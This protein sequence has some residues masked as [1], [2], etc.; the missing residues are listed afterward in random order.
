MILTL[1]GLVAVFYFTYRLF[2][3]LHQRRFRRRHEAQAPK[4]SRPQQ[5][6]QLPPSITVQAST[7]LSADA[8]GLPGSQAGGQQSG[9]VD[10][11]GPPPP[12][13]P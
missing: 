2:A 1:L 7:P 11:E 6:Q 8:P 13:E 3:V 5:Q 12:Y 9:V 10:S 4:T